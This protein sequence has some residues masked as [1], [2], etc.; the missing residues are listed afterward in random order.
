MIGNNK[1]LRVLAQRS[2]LYFKYDNDGGRDSRE[3]YLPFLEN[4]EYTES[5]RPNLATYDIVGRP[6]NVFAYLG[7]KSREI[8]LKFRIT[9]PHVSQ[10]IADIGLPNIFSN[11]IRYF[12][13]DK[14]KKRN[15]MKNFKRAKV[16]PPKLNYYKLAENEY[17]S[18][19][20]QDLDAI[21]KENS[22]NDK[23]LN[24]AIRELLYGELNDNKTN[25]KSFKPRPEKQTDKN[26]IE[27]VNL[28]ILWLNIIR[29][30]VVGNASNTSQGPPV[31]YLNHGTMFNNIPCVC[32]NYNIKTINNVGFD[33]LSLT[34][35]QLEITMTLSE[36]RTGSFNKFQPFKFIDNEAVAGWEAIV[37]Y[38]T[39]DPYIPK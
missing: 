7:A 20:E 37:E 27:A 12:S 8:Q 11:G 18:I 24:R 14:Q 30:S 23:L 2:Y 13:N 6:G 16:E 19:I 38:G 10:Y 5:Q 1:D 22:K 36:N 29:T 34:P 9:L 28:V 4:I 15:L 35:R 33:L 26:F 31:I 32:T 39:I 3:F 21:D 17:F 25:I